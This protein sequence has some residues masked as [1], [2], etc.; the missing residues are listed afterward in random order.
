MKKKIVISSNVTRTFIQDQLAWPNVLKTL[1]QKHY[2]YI[3]H[4]KFFLLLLLLF[5]NILIGYSYNIF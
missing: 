1:V 2:L 4:G 5:W 3:F